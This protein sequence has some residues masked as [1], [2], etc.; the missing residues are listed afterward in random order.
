[1][2]DQQQ[3]LRRE[4]LDELEWEPDLGASDL[5]L[6]VANDGV[7]TITGIAEN[8]AQKVAAERAVKRVKG[9]HAV[10][11][12][13]DV[14]MPIPHEQGDPELAAAVVHA[15]ERAAGV[16][17][18]RIRARVSEGWV[19]LEGEVNRNDE[20]T[21]A[22]QALHRLPGIRGITNLLT[23]APPEPCPLCC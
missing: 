15:L 14:R 16:P 18:D 2:N 22:E 6:T 20:R 19:R 17:H 11:N 7:V 13:I 21:A 9:V 5:D 23:I 10:V 4:L 1:M 12:D 8:Y 3:A